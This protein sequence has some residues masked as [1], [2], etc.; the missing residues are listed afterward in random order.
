MH[1][2]GAR[3]CNIIGRAYRQDNRRIFLQYNIRGRGVSYRRSTLK[4]T[5]LRDGYRFTRSGRLRT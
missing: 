4:S 5:L 1:C 2:A 3:A